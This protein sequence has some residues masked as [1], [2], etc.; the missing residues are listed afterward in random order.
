ML[1]V[2]QFEHEPHA[3]QEAVLRLRVSNVGP[4]D[5]EFGQVMLY[6]HAGTR[7]DGSAIARQRALAIP[8]MAAG[9]SGV[10]TTRL[11]VPMTVEGEVSVLLVPSDGDGVPWEAK[12]ER[13]VLQRCV[14]GVPALLEAA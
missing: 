2:E 7:C 3:N 4:D 11:H 12:G 13:L 1:S 6:W 5:Q 14:A 9:A 10:F 8:P